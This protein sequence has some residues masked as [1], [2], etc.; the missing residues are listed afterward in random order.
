MDAELAEVLRK[1]TVELSRIGNNINQIA[2]K[3]NEKGADAGDLSFLDSKMGE[4]LVLVREVRKYCYHTY[5]GGG[6]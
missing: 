4:I 6:R 1:L 5:S 3:W 2:R